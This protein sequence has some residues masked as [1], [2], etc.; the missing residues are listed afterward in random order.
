MLQDWREANLTGFTF[1]KGAKGNPRSYRPESLTS[2]VAVLL[3]ETVIKIELQ[4][5]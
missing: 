5:T 3:I 2:V 1:K 4:T